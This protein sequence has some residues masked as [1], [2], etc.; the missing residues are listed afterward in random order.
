M[1]IFPR[2]TA[3]ASAA[4]MVVRTA[5]HPSLSSSSHSIGPSTRCTFETNSTIRRLGISSFSSIFLSGGRWTRSI[6]R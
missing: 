3:L 1:A 2:L 4:S 5:Y 6:S